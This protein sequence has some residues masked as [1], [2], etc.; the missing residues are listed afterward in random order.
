MSL[1]VRLNSIRCI[2]EVNEASA[3]EEPYILLTAVQLQRTLGGFD[4]HNLRV[5]RYGIWEDFDAGEVVDVVD[6]PFWGLDSSPADLTDA[7]DAIFIVSL[8]ENDNGDP[9]AYRQLVEAVGAAS[10][11]ATVGETDRTVRASRL[12]QTIKGALNGI[13]LPFPFVLDDDHVGT[14]ILQL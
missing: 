6:P 2:E 5:S 1:T 8:M 11:A 3:S 14:E 12:L 7:S 13:D 10:L 4:V 9:S